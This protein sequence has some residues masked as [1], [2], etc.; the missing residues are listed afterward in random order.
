MTMKT[1]VVATL[2][3]MLTGCGLSEQQSAEYMT[4]ME[5]ARIACERDADLS[6]PA[7]CTDYQQLK[8]ALTENRSLE[9]YR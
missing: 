5:Q 7:R 1:T 2:A 3:L 9:S 6:A 8:R 4:E